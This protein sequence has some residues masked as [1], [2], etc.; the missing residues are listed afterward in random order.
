M[1][2]LLAEAVGT[3]GVMLQPWHRSREDTST[4]ISLSKEVSGSPCSAPGAGTKPGPHC[5]GQRTSVPLAPAT[6]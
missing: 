6:C 3:A 4:D 5:A 2:I 1:Q